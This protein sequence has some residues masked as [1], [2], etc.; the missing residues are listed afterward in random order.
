MNLGATLR[1]SLV[2]AQGGSPLKLLNFLDFVLFAVY[3]V[4]HFFKVLWLI[5]YLIKEFSLFV[6]SYIL[7]L[8]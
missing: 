4:E 5:A 2:G 7:F 3:K 8:L 6:L 1:P